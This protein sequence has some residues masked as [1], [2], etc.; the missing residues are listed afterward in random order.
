MKAVAVPEVKSKLE[1]FGAE[2]RALTPEEF[3][4]LVARQVDLWTKVATQANIR[5][6]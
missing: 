5:L 2:V 6:D 3:R 4:A 1:S